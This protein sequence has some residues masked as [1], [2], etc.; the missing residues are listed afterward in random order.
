M[1]KIIWKPIPEW[2]G[3]YEVNNIG[4]VKSLA[5]MT[6]SRSVKEKIINN[7][8]QNSGYLFAALYKFN[9]CNHYLVHR[10][11]AMAF[12]ENPQNKLFVNHINGIKTDNRVENLEWVTKSENMIH[13]YSTGLKK[14][15]E[16]HIKRLVEFNTK[17]KSIKIGQYNK[18]NELLNVYNSGVLAS[19][20]TNINYSCIMACAKG[21]YKN[22]STAGGFIWK[23]L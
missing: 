20:A 8:I 1:V 4:E 21:K 7:S 9:K 3:L 23:Y 10:L 14:I 13:A 6:K 18:N 2:E 11:V 17:T 22:H 19:K 16:K 12:I 5:R 15:T